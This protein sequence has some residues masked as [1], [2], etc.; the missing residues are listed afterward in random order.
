MG[1][2]EFVWATTGPQVACYATEDNSWHTFAFPGRVKL[3]A[4]DTIIC[5]AKPRVA[6]PRKPAGPKGRDPVPECQLVCQF[7]NYLCEHRCRSAGQV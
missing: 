5:Q 4:R 7:A 3:D 2:R 6:L 1:E